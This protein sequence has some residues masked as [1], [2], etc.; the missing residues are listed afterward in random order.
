MPEELLHKILSYALVLTDDAFSGH[1][2][3]DYG[4]GCFDLSRAHLAAA[5]PR[6]TRRVAGPP[7]ALLLVCKKWLRIGTP[8]LYEAVVLRTHAQLHAFALTLRSPHAPPCLGALVRR[9]R[10]EGT[11][12]PFLDRVVRRTPYVHT[13]LIGLD[14]ATEKGFHAFPYPSAGVREALRALR[15]KRL[16]LKREK[17]SR[18]GRVAEMVWLL[19]GAIRWWDSLVCRRL[20]YSVR[21]ELILGAATGS[22][23]LQQLLHTRK[24]FGYRPGRKPVITIYIDVRL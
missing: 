22:S 5:F 1:D 21:H 23:R 20:P 11:V 8:L 13:L 16:M 14:V 3:T 4:A 6:E 15:V 10:V 9:L 2:F 19:E 7:V 18:N 12:A 24:G 17:Y